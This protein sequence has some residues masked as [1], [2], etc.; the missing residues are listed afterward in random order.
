VSRSRFRT[1]EIEREIAV[2]VQH[3]LSSMRGLS[4]CWST[5]SLYWI[6]L[7]CIEDEI[8][9]HTRFLLMM[10]WMGLRMSGIGRGVGV[11]EP[12]RTTNHSHRWNSKTTTSSLYRARSKDSAANIRLLAARRTAETGNTGAIAPFSR[13]LLARA[14]LISPFL[15][16]SPRSSVVVIV[17]VYLARHTDIQTDT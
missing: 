9:D 11:S 6:V 3:H 17:E 14:S 7:V 10:G 1:R 13:S 15:P 5:H 4:E 2:K 16:L 8:Q 12:I